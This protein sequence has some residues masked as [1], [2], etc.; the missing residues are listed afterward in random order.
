MTTFTDEF[1]QFLATLDDGDPEGAH[2]ASL[3]ARELL[4]LR[5][6]LTPQAGDRLP[7]SGKTMPQEPCAVLH[8]DGWWTWVASEPH[9]ELAADWQLHVYRTAPPRPVGPIPMILFCH[10]CGLQHI[11]A[12]QPEKGWTNPPHRSHECQ[13]C[14]LI[15][16]P[17]D[18]ETTGV[19]NIQ[20]RGKNDSAIMPT[21]SPVAPDR[22]ALRG[23][24]KQ[25]GALAENPH[26][27][28][29]RR[30]KIAQL[31]QDALALLPPDRPGAERP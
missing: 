26:W 17:A 5:Q 15:W 27:T 3:L 6:Q 13:G 24:L 23:K 8:A 11:D 1:L 4:Q 19:Y 20:T 7:D 25:I 30:W 12:P 21:P 28:T 10:S 22:S 9:G 31:A 29:D 18:I 16:R 2:T 14:G